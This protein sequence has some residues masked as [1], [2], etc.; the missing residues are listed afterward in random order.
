MICFYL[1]CFGF[2]LCLGKPHPPPPPSDT[3]LHQHEYDLLATSVLLGIGLLAA[4]IIIAVTMAARNSSSTISDSEF[5]DVTI[6]E[7]NLDP[8]I[9]MENSVR[10]VNGGKPVRGKEISWITIKEFDDAPEFH[11]SDLHKKIAKEFTASRKRQFEYAE[12]TEYRCKFA[13]K[14][15]FLPCP[16]RIRVLMLS[17]CQAVKVESTEHCQEHV[18]EVD[19][20][21]ALAS[22]S[23]NY[24]WTPRMN[25]FV[26]QCVQNHGKPKVA[27]RNM[28]D[29]GCF[30]GYLRP[31]MTQLY[32]KIHA[33][34]KEMNKNP[35]MTDTF[36]MRQLVSNYIDEPEDPNEAFIPFHEIHDDDGENVRFNIIFSSTNCLAR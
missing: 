20:N 35:S 21:T 31:T 6:S 28:E 5:E 18:H 29:A 22:A 10:V 15:R 34:K 23:G 3:L 17:H 33:L 12:V 19:K 30:Q 26:E 27:L 16:W 14:K 11:A 9:E 4:A 24:I 25:E 32:N 36:Q 8:A 13:R 7:P 1:T 2:M